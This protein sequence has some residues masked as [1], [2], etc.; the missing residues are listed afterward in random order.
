MK[1]R[2][3]MPVLG[4]LIWAIL[5]ACSCSLPS[6]IGIG[7]YK[8]PTP[9]LTDCSQTFNS[10]LE[11]QVVALINQA[12]SS[13]GLSPLV[14]NDLLTGAA[15]RHSTDMAC[16]DFV[17]DTGSDGATWHELMVE[18]G[19]LVKYGG[20]GVTGGYANDPAAVVQVWSQ[21]ADGIVY[22]NIPTEIGVGVVSKD[23]TKYGVY[24]TLLYA[25]PNR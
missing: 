16:H 11:A 21:Q 19:Y 25:L 9:T 6:M 24:W 17:D 7:D 18:G 20:I 14:L 2:I 10:D 8:L 22:D 3:L 12:R 13:H 23:G 15:R 4:L 5:L 1:R